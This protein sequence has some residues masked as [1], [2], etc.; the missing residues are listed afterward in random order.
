VSY[1]LYGLGSALG[2]YSIDIA[3]QSRSL[4]QLSD[5]SDEAF[6]DSASFIGHRS[7]DTYTDELGRVHRHNLPGLTEPTELSCVLA[8]FWA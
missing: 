3:L 2:T 8:H 7:R 6:L 1:P 5:Y 4:A